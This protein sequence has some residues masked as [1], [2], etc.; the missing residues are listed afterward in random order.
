MFGTRN[1]NRPGQPFV[2]AFSALT[3]RAGAH[4]HVAAMLMADFHVPICL[5]ATRNPLSEVS[6]AVR[7]Y[8]A[9]IMAKKYTPRIKNAS[10]IINPL[11]CMEAENGHKKTRL[12]ATCKRGFSI[13]SFRTLIISFFNMKC[14][15]NENEVIFCKNFGFLL[16][17]A[18]FATVE[19]SNP[20]N[21]KHQGSYP[22][23]GFLDIIL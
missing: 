1:Q 6:L 16:F 12:Q 22:L 21:S 10:K 3:N 5:S 17:F 11:R 9:A 13:S 23:D 7:K 8:E 18:V 4:I 2:Y 20:V 15:R 19:P 14:K